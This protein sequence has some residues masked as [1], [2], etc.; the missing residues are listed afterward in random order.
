VLSRKFPRDSA[1][2]IDVRPVDPSAP[3]SSRRGRPT[4]SGTQRGSGAKVKRA[5]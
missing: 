2:R 3:G 1:A 4:A 5:A